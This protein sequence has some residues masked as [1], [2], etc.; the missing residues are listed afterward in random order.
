LALP[1]LLT[2]GAVIEALEKAAGGPT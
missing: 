2:V 1:E